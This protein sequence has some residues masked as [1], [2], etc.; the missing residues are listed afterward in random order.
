MKRTEDLRRPITSPRTRVL[1]GLST[2][3]P[4]IVSD[5]WVS[6]LHPLRFVLTAVAT[7][8][9]YWL[10][11]PTA[12]RSERAPLRAGV[13]AALSGA[14]IGSLWW[15]VAGSGYSV[16]IPLSIGS[17]TALFSL[18][19][20]EGRRPHRPNG[21]PRKEPSVAA[22]RSR[23]SSIQAKSEVDETTDTELH[24]TNSLPERSGRW[25]TLSSGYFATRRRNRR[26]AVIHTRSHGG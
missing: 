8:L 11:T 18:A 3:L 19:P 26:S 1:M 20:V 17:C 14:G 16:W 13:L 4:L 15:A 21:R 10:L 12:E 6:G 23:L 7:A 9:G 2:A 25:V 24:R 5:A 22:R